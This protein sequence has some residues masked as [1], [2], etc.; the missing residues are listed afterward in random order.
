MLKGD[1]LYISVHIILYFGTELD[2]GYSHCLNTIQKCVQLFNYLSLTKMAAV[3]PISC[4]SRLD[5]TSKCPFYCSLLNANDD[6]VS[7]VEP[8]APCGVF[9]NQVIDKQEYL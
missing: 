3:R 6:S 9:T 1:G 5:I 8:S 4:H 7:G 2:T